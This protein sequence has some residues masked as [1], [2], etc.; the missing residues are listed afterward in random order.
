VKLISLL[1]RASHPLHSHQRPPKPP[2]TSDWLRFNRERALSHALSPQANPIALTTRCWAVQ[3]TTR[4][5]D[6]DTFVKVGGILSG[7]AG[8]A[9]GLG[10]PLFFAKME[11]RDKARVEDIRETNRAN[12]KATGETLS[13]EELQELRPKRYMDQREV[14]GA[15]PLK[16]YDM[17]H[18]A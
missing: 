9:C 8:I 17:M 7:V 13:S 2:S 4:A 16:V 14:R 12:L 11:S 15:H 6:D 10:I 1:Y 5:M 18:A 3:V